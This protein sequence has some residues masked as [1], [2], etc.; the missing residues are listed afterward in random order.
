M[1]TD[2]SRAQEAAWEARAQAQ[3]YL[4]GSGGASQPQQ[5]SRRIP[6][7][8]PKPVSLDACPPQAPI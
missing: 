3:K 1:V 4:E 7:P 2:P 8:G 6:H 5:Q